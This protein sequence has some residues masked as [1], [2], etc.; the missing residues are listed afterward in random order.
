MQL[1]NSCAPFEFFAVQSRDL[2]Y[3]RG[4]DLVHAVAEDRTV[5][6]PIQQTFWAAPLGCL[7]IT[8][9]YRG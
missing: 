4:P 5:L 3:L 9:V 7:S 6:M 8:S 1:G 2:S